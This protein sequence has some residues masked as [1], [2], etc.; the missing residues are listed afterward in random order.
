MR[1]TLVIFNTYG[2]HLRAL[3]SLYQ[4]NHILLP[5]TKNPFNVSNTVHDVN[6]LTFEVQ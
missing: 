3:I 6:C 5:V 2:N 1:F 4:C